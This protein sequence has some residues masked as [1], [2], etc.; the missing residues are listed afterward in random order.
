MRSA[1]IIFLWVLSLSCFCSG[2]NA[3]FKS[4][5]NTV[6]HWCFNEL[7][8]DTI[9]DSGE[10][11][12]DGM[13]TA[14][15]E[16]KEG[17]YGKAISFN[18]YGEMA[19][20]PEMGKLKRVSGFEIKAIIQIPEYNSTKSF[21]VIHLGEKDVWA[22]SIAIGVGHEKTI[23]FFTNGDILGGMNNLKVP[24]SDTLLNKW[25]M[26]GVSYDRGVK[27]LFVDN[28]EVAQCEI[29]SLVIDG[30]FN[31][32]I[33]GDTWGSA[34][35]QFY[36]DIDEVIINSLPKQIEIISSPDIIAFCG[37][38]YEYAI[39]LD[40][41]ARRPISL[42]LQNGPDNIIIVDTVVYWIPQLENVGENQ[43]ALIAVDADSDT[44]RQEMVIKVIEKRIEFAL[45][46]P[47][48]DTTI[49]EI[50]SLLFAAIPIGPNNGEIHYLWRCDEQRVS[51][52]ATFKYETNYDSQGNHI[53]GLILYDNDGYGE[54][55]WNILVNNTKMPPYV[56]SP[57]QNAF[58]RN[59]TSF[60]W[61]SIDPGLEES[62]TM[63]T[64]EIVD[65]TETA[66]LKTKDSIIDTTMLFS[67]LIGATPFPMGCFFHW[68]I[69]AFDANGYN[70]GF[71]P[72]YSFYYIGDEQNYLKLSQSDLS[73]DY[74][75]F[76][77]SPNPFNPSTTIKITI[78]EKK[79][80]KIEIRIMQL[81]GKVVKKIAFNNPAPGYMQIN[82]DAKDE[83]GNLCPNGVYL[84]QMKTRNYQ[85][86]LKMVLAK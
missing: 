82:W 56:I 41:N 28:V 7:N 39:A 18:D 47:T 22:I 10:N 61:V 2:Q 53:V 12:Y 32:L 20:L 13:L 70:T 23:S 51:T 75:L 80:N 17:L 68:R 16:R 40:S 55:T 3:C 54:Y 83:N 8:G 57:L 42:Q 79:T 84:Y 43:I 4:G 58:V 50:D 11:Q 64:I 76:Q 69:A 9:Y 52:S 35:W 26:V 25:F 21:P 78:P 81:N 15:V 77:N 1:F 71:S 5:S 44:A 38:A 49:A 30:E 27:R 34:A 24:L 73:L 45:L 29:D 33:G 72:Y 36:G 59:D 85:K 14:G 46:L 67:D 63:Y 65:T 31:T 6:A 48:G 60:T 19:I 66:M 74:S 86:T 37:I 62:T